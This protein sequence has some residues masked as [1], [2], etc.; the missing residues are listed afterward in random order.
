MDLNENQTRKQ[1][2]DVLLREQGWDVNNR[3]HVI[4]EVDTK[5]SDFNACDYKTVGET[6]KNDLE[7]KYADYLLLDTL[8]NPLAIIEAKRTSKDSNIGQ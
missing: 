6:L 4:S 2:I 3:S 8:R 1:K 7:S 5:Q